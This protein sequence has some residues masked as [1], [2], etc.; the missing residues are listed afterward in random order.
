MCGIAGI[1]CAQADRR[2]DPVVLTR[3]TDRLRHRGPDDAGAV[4][5]GPAALGMR[6]LEIIDLATGHQPMAGEDQRVWVVF[7][8]E[9][10][11][12]RELTDRQR[13]RGHVFQTR[14]DTEVI[15]H[16]YEDLGLGVLNELDGMFAIAVWDESARTLV[17]ARDRIGIKPLYYA[18]LPDQLVFAS[19]IKALLEHPEVDRTLDIPSVS[20]YLAYE[21]VPAPHA[22]F[23]S[24]RKLPAGHWLSYTDGRVKVEP[25]WNLDFSRPSA[26]DEREAAEKLRATLDAAVRRHLVSDVPLGV[27]LSGGLDSGTVAALAASHVTGRLQTFS[28]GFTDPSFDEAA[29]ARRVARAVGSEH[30]EEILDARAALEL[31]DRLPDLLDEPLGDA[32][33]L[34]TYL[35]S[36]FARRS[37]TVALSGDGGDEL[38]AGYPTYQ[39][40]RL[41]RAYR[42]VPRVVRERVIRP[43]V[44]AMPVSH[45]NLSL[46]FRLKRFVE[47]MVDDDVERHARWMGSFTPEEQRELLTPEAAARIEGA[48]YDTVRDTAVQVAAGDPLARLLYLDL[49]GYLGEGV[50]TKV[51]RASMACSLE[52]RVPLLDRAVVELAASLPAHM[53][54]RGLTTK[55]VLKQAMR[56]G[57][58]RDIIDRRKQG[59]GVPLARWFRRELA[60]LLADVLAPAALRRH[61]LFRPEVVERLVREHQ[62]GARD[63]RKKLYT[64]LVF[65]LWAA[66]YR[67][68]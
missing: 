25:Y 68:S 11:N 21:Y 43:L 47:G 13:A 4:V 12:Y 2:P 14:S 38:F 10:Y 32:S 41:A 57:L 42:R 55:Y 3:M 7:N 59:F 63:H 23:R 61:G 27:F 6:R 17:L 48:P 28:V 44:E 36:R 58:P 26:L 52:V 30:H 37:V 9:I 60:P 31:V 40:H 54:L 56:D 67:P 66:R 20:R 49:K 33:I 15:V 24:V 46:D 64:L 51:D 5:R 19:E 16:G 39:A 45:G 22:I 29:H 35:L 34:P 65:Q 62:N 1:V 50:L 8:G 18:V 53:K